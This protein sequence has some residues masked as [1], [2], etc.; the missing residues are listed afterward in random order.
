MAKDNTGKMLAERPAAI[1]YVDGLNL[2]KRLLEKYPEYRWLNIIKLCEILLPTHEIRL[3]RYFTSRIKPPLENQEVAINQG[4]YLEALNSLGNRISISYGKMIRRDRV[5]PVAPASLRPDG[6]PTLA[7]VATVEEK[8]SDVALAS[9]MVLDA[10]RGD[11][12]MFVL[13]SNDSDFRPTLRILREE[14]GVKV[15]LFSPVSQPSSS[16]LVS[17]KM[18]IKIIRSSALQASQ[19]PSHIHSNKGSIRKPHAWT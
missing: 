6:K 10:A 14:L 1:V 2:D 4:I 3:V 8:G 11:A 18:L 15:G 17:E 7:R 19:L 12:E 16:L 5:F 13:L 9:F